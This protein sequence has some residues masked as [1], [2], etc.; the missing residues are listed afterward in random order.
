MSA[1]AE[2]AEKMSVEMLWAMAD[3]NRRHAAIRAAEGK[4]ATADKYVRQAR[5]L[6][7]MAMAKEADQ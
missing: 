6:E 1:W 4:Q 3:T 7:A 2:N 5:R